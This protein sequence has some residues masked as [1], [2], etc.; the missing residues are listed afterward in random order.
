MVL[1]SWTGEGWA[2]RQWRCL[3]HSTHQAAWGGSEEGGAH[4]AWG[5]ASGCILSIKINAAFFRIP[6]LLRPGT[7]T[8]I[9]LY[10]LCI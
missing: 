4:P 5:Q 10:K 3:I 1:P 8:Y 2:H 7:Y 9:C 6:R